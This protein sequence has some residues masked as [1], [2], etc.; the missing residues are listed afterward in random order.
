MS[1]RVVVDENVGRTSPLWLA[2]QKAL[3]SEDWDYLFLAEAHP[4]I[5]DVEILDKLLKPGMVLLTADC[6]L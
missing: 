2:F 6:V 3:G 5:P 1:K 4:G